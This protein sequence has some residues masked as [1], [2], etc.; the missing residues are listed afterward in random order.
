MHFKAVQNTTSL[1]IYQALIAVAILLGSV[2][3]SSSSAQTAPEP[4]AQDPGSYAALADLLENDKTREKLIEQLRNLPPDTDRPSVPAQAAQDPADVPVSQR[5]AAGLQTFTAQLVDDLRETVVIMKSLALGDGVPGSST[6]LWA[7]TLK[8]LLI[9]VLATL[10][11]YA[12]LRMLAGFVFARLNI[13]IVKD[14]PSRTVT[15]TPGH[16][17]HRSQSGAL[18][19]FASL[20]LGRKLLG[21]A[22]AFV[23]DVAASLLAALAGYVAVMAF[24]AGDVQATVFALQFLTAFVLIEIA[25][26]VS[27]GIFATRYEQLR[28]L[29][30]SP[31]SATYWNHWLSLLI[32][33][34]GYGLMVIVPVATAIFRP[35]VGQVA[36]LFIML[37]VYIYGVR[38]V[39]KNRK[40]VSAA[41]VARAE[42]A[43]AAVFGTL[44]RVL[45]RSWH[46]LAL[47][48]LTILLVVSQAAQQY[49]LIFMARATL[50]SVAA[51][52]LG[53]ILA[54]ALTSLATRR[55][56][57]P[58]DWRRALPLLES[59]LNAYVPMALKALRLAILVLVTLVVLDAWH[60]FDLVSWLESDRGQATVAL[61]FHVGIIL[62]IAA[63]S[64]TVIASIIEHRL[65][66]TSHRKASEREKT[67]LMLFRN[68]AA[69]VIAT[70]TVLI[71]LSQIGI[72]VGPLIAG[73]G[74][75]GLA[76]GFGAQKLVQDVIT[77]IFIQLE[78]GMNQND[79][80]E[81]AGLF[82]TV[83][84]ITI[85]SVVIRTLDGGY[86][87]IPFSTIDK[88]TNHTRD[89]GYHYAEYNIAHRESVDEAIAQLEL[90]FQD[91][92]QDPEVAAEVLE[93]ISIPGVTA[94]N[95]RGF[96]IRVL[97]KTTPGNQWLIQRAF[98]RLMK[99]RFDAAGIEL[100]YP[101]TVLHFGRDKSGHAEPVDIRG[102][103]TLKEVKGET[104]PSF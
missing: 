23:V 15:S 12:I 53:M 40:N 43:S 6:Q 34:T 70:M 35:S 93:D 97:I 16:P 7:N 59:R 29:P 60:A 50:Q 17:G 5:L 45:A 91:M 42:Q 55:L 14:S 30:L 86:H 21:V 19:R 56:R 68:A 62:A 79:I 38:G 75:A 36:G 48:Y 32:G 63:L 82:G 54:A 8:A 67:L 4:A 49:A 95:E 57:I 81:L 72:N 51:I 52:A 94:L 104:P 31:E 101:H 20:A 58:D 44:I 96:S 10:A 33:L 25:K 26:S 27:R 46:L 90:A 3:T 80:V 24:T 78:N 28:L 37:A 83:E 22:A 1:F 85:R 73:A 39:W 9:A 66:A 102:V 89:Y 65:G 64:W 71:V 41:L 92:M 88:L 47:A 2:L 103:D 87:L 99:Q 11:A 13:W 100:P 74:V 84:K 69:V 18:Y 98:N 76:I 77:G 61:L